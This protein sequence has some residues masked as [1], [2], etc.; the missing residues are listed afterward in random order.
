[1]TGMTVKV[2]EGVEIVK[3]AVRKVNGV[4]MLFTSDGKMLANQ[5]CEGHFFYVGDNPRYTTFRTAFLVDGENVDLGPSI[6]N[7]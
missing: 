7:G 3:L 6:K 1:M 4:D 5:G 2:P